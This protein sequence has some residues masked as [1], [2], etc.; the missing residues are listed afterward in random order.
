MDLD[1]SNLHAPM[2]AEKESLAAGLW[3][4]C[5]TIGMI[6]AVLW[7]IEGINALAFQHALSNYGIVPRTISGLFGI[8]WAPLLHASWSHL[9]SNSVGILLLGGILMLRSEKAFWAVTVLGWFASGAGTWLIGR[10]NCVH[11]GASGVVLAY[12]GYLLF[13]GIFERRIGSL[14][15]SLLVFFLW[16]GLLWSAVPWKVGA[17]I[18]WEAH[19]FGLLGGVAVAKLMAPRRVKPVATEFPDFSGRRI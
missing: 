3:R 16:G 12:F 13:S 5:V 10:G 6:F 11:I 15:L 4:R 14:L 19:L 8:L 1:V 18:S 7:G 17:G 9:W 2:S